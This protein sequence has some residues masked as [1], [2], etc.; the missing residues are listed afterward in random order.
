M[1]TSQRRH[2]LEAWAIV[3]VAFL[4]AV[5]FLL[6]GGH[7][8]TD[9]IPPTSWHGLRDAISTIAGFNAPALVAA[10]AGAVV[11]LPE[12]T[13]GAVRWK[14]ELLLAW[15]VVPVMGALI[16]SI[17]KPM[18]VGRYLIVSAP[19]LALLGA[20]ALTAIRLRW[21]AAGATMV[22]LLLSA[23]EIAAWYQREPEDW[24]GAARL[25]M[26]GDPQRRH[27]GALPGRRV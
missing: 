10:G 9:W 5:P 1:S 4:P 3:A 25:A 2:L 17:L 16:V 22:V 8:G 12:R 15:A 6:V 26:S 20:V 18:L 27:G 23:K 14:G 24:R 19:A 21:V 7:S 13:P 11:L